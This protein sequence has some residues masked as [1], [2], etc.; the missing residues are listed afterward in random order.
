[1]LLVGQVLAAVEVEAL[2]RA[3]GGAEVVLRA[4]CGGQV[5]VRAVVLGDLED[6]CG[7]L[8]KSGQERVERRRYIAAISG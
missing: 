7:E 5:V 3:R 8:I 6:F 2:H 1:M 4:A